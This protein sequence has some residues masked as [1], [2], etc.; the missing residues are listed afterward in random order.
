MRSNH[1][2]KSSFC[3]EIIFFKS[4][5]QIFKIKFLTKIWKSS[6]KMKLLVLNRITRVFSIIYFMIKTRFKLNTITKVVTG[7]V[8][9]GDHFWIKMQYFRENSPYQNWTWKKYFRPELKTVI[10][11]RKKSFTW[12][13]F[14]ARG[15]YL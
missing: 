5:F 8:S 13:C 11:D 10:P 6:R 12:P 7:A 9:V 1:L 4:N 3:W 15:G 14:W 2:A